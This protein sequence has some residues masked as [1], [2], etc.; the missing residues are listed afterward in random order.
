M[1]LFPV[2]Y[3]MDKLMDCSRMVLVGG[4]TRTVCYECRIWEQTRAVLG[5]CRNNLIGFFNKKCIRLLAGSCLVGEANEYALREVFQVRHNFGEKSLELTSFELRFVPYVDPACK[6]A[7]QR[8]H[9]SNKR[10]KTKFCILQ[11]TNPG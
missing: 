3:G 7:T 10:R 5:P 6:L 2:C 1:E 4:H 9:G 11:G 8:T